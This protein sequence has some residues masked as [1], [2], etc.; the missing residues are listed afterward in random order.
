VIFGE[1]LGRLED[2]GDEVA[3]DGGHHHPA[4]VD[5]GQRGQQLA[6]RGH[7]SGMIEVYL[8]RNDIDS[9]SV[10]IKVYVNGNQDQFYIWSDKD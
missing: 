9:K 8:N 1:H 6:Q 2:L 4:N 7:V 3:H 5:I 10:E